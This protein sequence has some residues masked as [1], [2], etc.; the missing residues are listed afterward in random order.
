VACQGLPTPL[1]GAAAFPLLEHL[2]SK[3]LDSCVCSRLQGSASNLAPGTYQLVAQM[4]RRVLHPSSCGQDMTLQQAG[5]Q[6]G[7]EMLMLEPL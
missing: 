7:Q 4:P 3:Q 6:K 5:L 1:Q 2:G